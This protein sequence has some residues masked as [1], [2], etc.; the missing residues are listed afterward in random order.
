MYRL[1]L[2]P[3]GSLAEVIFFTEM[4]FHFIDIFLQDGS[5]V[6]LGTVA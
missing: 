3:K 5:N 4:I 2:L 6:F 1:G